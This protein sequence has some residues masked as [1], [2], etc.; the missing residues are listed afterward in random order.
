MA[1]ALSL[2]FVWLA[3]DEGLELWRASV[4]FVAGAAL[5]LASVV[6]ERRR[7]NSAA[8]RSREELETCVA[9]R[10]EE[11]ARTNASLRLSEERVREQ[12][13]FL[14]NVLNHIPC[15]VFWKDSEGLYL[16]SNGVNARDLGKGSAAEVV[17]RTDHQ[18]LPC[19]DDADF[20]V[21]C[22]REVMGT[23]RPLRNIEEKQTRH[24]GTVAALL[25]S[26]VPLRDVRGQVIG[27]LGTYIEIT[28]RKRAEELL[29]QSE[30]RFRSAFDNAAI[31]MALVS[32]EGRFLQVNR[33]LCALV[34][35]PEAELLALDFQTITHPDDLQADLDYVRRLLAAE[36]TT[37]QMEK[38]Y[39]HKLGQVVWVLLSVSL[40]RDGRGDPVYFISQIQDI[41]QRKWAEEESRQ[42]RQAAE[43]A[44]RAKSQFLANMSHEIRTPLN[45]IL[46]MTEL[47]LDT[48]LTPQQREFLGTVRASADALLAVI[49][50]ILDFSKIEAGKL[51]LDPV[52]F[53]LR[54]VL[55]DMLR[56]L[57]LQAHA[58][59]LEL[60]CHIE[61]DVPDA[62][63]G[64]AGRL[65]QVLINLVGNAI[66]FTQ[67][68][69]VVLTASFVPCT[70]PPAPD[71]NGCR[72]GYL[73]EVTLQFDVRDTGIGIPS[74]KLV[75][76]FDP[77]VQADGSTSRRHGGTGLGLSISTKLVELLGGRLWAESRPG[78]GSVFHFTVRLGLQ[79]LSPSQLIRRPENIAG[80]RVLV[81]DDNATNRH[82][83]AKTLQSWR[84]CPI[85]AACGPGAIRAAAEA[86]QAFS[87]ILL[88]SG[89]PGD[90]G[91]ELAAKLV[92]QPS[93]RE[94]KVLLLMSAGQPEVNARRREVGVA[95]CLTKPIGQL[96]LLQ[97]MQ[98]TL[99]IV[100]VDA[101]GRNILENSRS[102]QADAP[103]A[104]ARPLRILLAEDNLVNQRL[105]VLLLERQGHQVRVAVN[106]KEALAAL[107]KEPYD[108]VLMDVQMP[109]M[110]G[111]EAVAQL[112]RS[113]AGTS[114]HLPVVALT[115]HAMNGDR[116]RCLAA[117][118]DGYLSK[119]I[120]RVELARALAEF[121]PP[122]TD[123][124]EAPAPV[125]REFDRGALLE[126][127]G[128]REAVLR[129]VIDLFLVE[130][131]RV[132]RKLYEA[133]DR[134]DAPAVQESAHSLKGMVASLAAPAAAR[135]AARLETLARDG[136]LSAATAILT[137]L[138]RHLD[139]LRPELVKARQEAVP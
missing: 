106:G 62:L 111:I 5:S 108:L 92:A 78:Q 64:D 52:R 29:R 100:L 118:M 13:E 93:C 30:T 84:M 3:S 42:A 72:A 25:T 81:V 98:T 17:G 88:D 90:E 20:Y 19:K 110:D 137:D 66:K 97:A 37:Y 96:D 121:F 46:G 1:F 70:S 6:V 60:A 59:G 51:R 138:Q 130:A 131:P 55:G 8:R 124:D 49:N 82:I 12:Q 40:V 73:R 67:E 104:V 33:S 4:G 128:G 71:S 102:A 23:G 18:L 77:F 101:K 116:E 76:I 94:A 95:A 36:I 117:G 120:H 74:E 54:D 105:G 133:V 136:D 115:A 38:R 32:P 107:D 109:E 89:M 75:S 2:L 44:N 68:G 21:R 80:L 43:A 61:D 63:V 24:D 58:K 14:Q 50:D 39:F 69:E 35:Y 53:S 79:P 119:P 139:A 83:L 22:D 126:C 85:E 87:L 16:G 123:Q 47:A 26:K 31:G 112:R 134:G 48:D 91:L 7:A 28:E 127:L 9:V 11:L 10:T 45:G 125:L 132:T 57:A 114:R 86:Q 103:P 15:A 27:V 99:G 122:E 34:G 56:P 135:S 41:N 65:R 129:E 113:E